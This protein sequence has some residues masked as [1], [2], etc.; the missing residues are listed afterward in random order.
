MTVTNTP[1]RSAVREKLGQLRPRLRDLSV[2]LLNW[3]DHTEWEHGQ[4]ADEAL[5]ALTEEI[6]ALR[7]HLGRRESYLL[8]E[9]LIHP[10]LPAPSTQQ[11]GHAIHADTC[12]MCADDAEAFR[13]LQAERD[14]IEA[15]RLTYISGVFEIEQYLA[16]LKDQITLGREVPPTAELV[17][18]LSK[19]LSKLSQR[20][21]RAWKR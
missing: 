21:Q 3:I 10:T 7:S 1:T 2:R 17:T 16:Y 18:R 15:G 14:R 4:Y 11:V 20:H 13:H 19:A 5:A 6:V 8:D 9:A 12:S